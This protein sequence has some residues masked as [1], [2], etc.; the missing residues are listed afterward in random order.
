MIG[1]TLDGKYRLTRLLGAGGM[2]SVYVASALDDG[3]E[4]AVKLIRSDELAASPGMVKR[5]HREARATGKIDTPNIV[6]VF[7]SGVDPETESP[8]MAMELLRGLD[9]YGFVR[10]VGP[11]APDTVLRIA[12]QACLGL[13]AAHAAG[14]IHRDIK[15]ANIFLARTEP[16]GTVTVKILDFGIAKSIPDPGSGESKALTRT[17]MLLGSPLYMS[18]EQARGAKRI[19]PRTDLWSLGMVMFHLLAGRAVYQHL[20]HLG[21]LMIAICS[22]PPPSVQNVAPWVPKEI[23]AILDRALR[24]DPEDRYLGAT[25]MLAAVR[26]LLPG[27]EALTEDRLVGVSNAQRAVVAARFEAAEAQADETLES[28]SSP[29]A[30]SRTVLVDGSTV[31]SSAD[32]DELASTEASNPGAPGARAHDFTAHGVASSGIVHAPSVSRRSTVLL[33]AGAAAVS[34]L[35]VGLLRPRDSAPPAVGAAL[36]P[37]M[38]SSL[39]AAPASAEAAAEAALPAVDAGSVAIPATPLAARAPSAGPSTRQGPSARKSSSDATGSRAKPSLDP[40]GF[41]DRK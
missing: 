6:R 15:P 40:N 39:P 19:D 7:D 30:P 1:L 38:V 27:G 37:A 25:A 11:I 3:R 24:L 10:Q 5:F 31:A 26:A 32:V 20:D 28:N 21:A 12:A 18:P 14:V 34:G 9:L 36:A 29:P 2:G 22:A 33:L 8:Y 13:E 17:G 23:A 4:V 41:G 35:G 16:P